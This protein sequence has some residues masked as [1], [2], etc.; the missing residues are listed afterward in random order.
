MGGGVVAALRFGPAGKQV[1]GVGARI[2]SGGATPDGDEGRV[3]A[4]TEDVGGSSRL[5]NAARLVGGRGG[6]AFARAVGH[7]TTLDDHLQSGQ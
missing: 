7:G 6:T 2:G 1:V 4:A 3:P 5:V